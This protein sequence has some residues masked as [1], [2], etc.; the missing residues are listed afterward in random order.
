MSVPPKLTNKSDAIKISHGFKKKK[1]HS[2][3]EMEQII[4]A[5]WSFSF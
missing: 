1:N 4:E 5:I 2:Y 3:A